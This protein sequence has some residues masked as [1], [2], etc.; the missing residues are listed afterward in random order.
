MLLILVASFFIELNKY[1][2]YFKY[3]DMY[4]LLIT[5]TTSSTNKEVHYEKFI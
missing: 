2:I 4:G 1:I 3:L 5:K